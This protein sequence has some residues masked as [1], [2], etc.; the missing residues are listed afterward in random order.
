M[1]DNFDWRN[2]GANKIADLKRICEENDIPVAG[3]RGKPEYVA[4][5]SAWNKAKSPS[6][7]PSPA[8]RLRASPASS[9]RSTPGRP[10]KV[11]TCPEKLGAELQNP[12]FIASFIVFLLAF[13]AAFY[14][15][16]K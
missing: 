3:P 4:A 10:G 15:G 11:A 16:S 7:K 2:I 1:G 9:A 13:I 5:V 14:Y 12:L 8:A 6:V